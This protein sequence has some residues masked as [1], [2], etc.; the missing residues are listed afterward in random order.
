MGVKFGWQSGSKLHMCSASASAGC[1]VPVGLTRSVSTTICHFVCLPQRVLG[2]WVLLSKGEALSVGI[3]MSQS[4]F[5][6][7]WNV[8]CAVC[9]ELCA[10]LMQDKKK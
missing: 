3:T 1:S 5:I 4:G 7:V 2:G 6:I 10:L 9:S 8:Q